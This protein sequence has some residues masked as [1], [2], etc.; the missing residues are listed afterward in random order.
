M[1]SATCADSVRRGPAAPA[2]SC[3]VG[4][5][6]TAMVPDRGG[7]GVDGGWMGNGSSLTPGAPL[8][9]NRASFRFDETEHG[10]N[11]WRARRCIRGRA[12]QGRQTGHWRGPP[13]REGAALRLIREPEDVSNRRG[14]QARAPVERMRKRALDRGPFRFSDS[15]IR[16]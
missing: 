9:D 8:L 1:S 10:A 12:L 15:R 6:R 11:P 2:R 5:A 14:V 4:P 7:W 13:R 3:S 16:S